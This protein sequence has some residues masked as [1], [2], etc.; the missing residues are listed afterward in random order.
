MRIYFDNAATTYPKPDGVIEAV[1]H[2][3]KD[4]GCNINRS[5]YAGAYEAGDTV[6]ETR[7]L[8][9]DMFNAPDERN[10]IFTENVTMS[11]NMAIKGLLKAGDHALTTAAEHNAVM[12]PLVKMAD[13]GMISFDR[14]ACDVTGYT[15]A[16]MVEKY[17]NDRTKAVVMAHAS[18]VN[19]RVRPVG[20]IGRLC[21]E[22]GLLFIVDAA[23]TAGVLDIDMELMCIDVL[24]FTGHKGLLGP[25]GI[26]GFA[27]GKR[28]EKLLD[29]A[30]EGGTGSVSHLET[31]PEFL[32]DRFEPGTLNIPGIYGLNAGLKFIGRTGTEAIR[33]RENML[34][35]RFLKGIEGIAGVRVIGREAAE[36][37]FICSGSCGD[38]PSRETERYVAVVSLTF[39]KWD[40]AEAA[41]ALES[42]FGIETRVGLHCAPSAHKTLGTYPEGTVRFSF[43]YFNTEEETDHGIKAVGE[44]CKRRG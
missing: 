24:C 44:L 14:V 40:A 16:D 29:T 9:K 41:Y 19:G 10:I 2:Y 31:M 34:C 1:T 37:C 5:S 22:R 6:L 4:I 15:D 12:R 32:P 33:R 21:R 23:Q 25:Q 43:G 28:A 8:L 36:G 7:Q 13:D 20:E 30:F 17:I 26:G 42:E 3:M 39:D 18:N 35:G 27:I 38:C 11:L